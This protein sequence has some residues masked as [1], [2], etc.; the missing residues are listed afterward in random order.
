MVRSAL[1]VVRAERMKSPD[2][3]HQRDGLVRKDGRGCSATATVR[4]SGPGSPGGSH[5][6]LRPRPAW[7]EHGTRTG[8]GGILGSLPRHAD[9]RLDIL[10]GNRARLVELSRIRA[11]YD[12]PHLSYSER[13]RDF[14]PEITKGRK[15]REISQRLAQCHFAL[16][17]DIR[18]SCFL[19]G[20]ALNM[21]GVTLI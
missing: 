6:E 13:L 10:H 14:I 17:R 15:V 21:V 12:L 11:S 16:F 20:D 3:F 1:T 18:K 4:L 2:E 7:R 9:G 8:G 19:H 5:H